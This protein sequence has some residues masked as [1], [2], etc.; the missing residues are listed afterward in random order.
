[1]ASM[2]QDEW[3]KRYLSSSYFSECFQLPASTAASTS[4]AS[5]HSSQLTP[6]IIHQHLRQLLPNNRIVLPPAATVQVGR[7]KGR[8]A[9]YKLAVYHGWIVLSHTVEFNSDVFWA[10][11]A[12]SRGET[13]MPERQWKHCERK[14]IAFT[15]WLLLDESR[16]ARC[17]T[18]LEQ[19]SLSWAAIQKLNYFDEQS[20]ENILSVAAISL[21]SG[22]GNRKRHTVTSKNVNSIVNSRP[23]SSPI[24][25]KNSTRAKNNHRRG[26]VEKNVEHSRLS[27]TSTELQRSE[28]VTETTHRNMHAGSSKSDL[29]LC[30]EKDVM[31][32]TDV[33]ED[34]HLIHAPIPDIRTQSPTTALMHD[35]NNPQQMTIILRT[36]IDDDVMTVTMDGRSAQSLQIGDVSSPA[37]DYGDERAGSDAMIYIPTLREF[38]HESL[39]LALASAESTALS[40]LS[41][42]VNIRKRRT[43]TVK[44]IKPILQSHKRAKSIQIS[45]L[46]ILPSHAVVSALASEI[47]SSRECNAGDE[48]VV[49]SEFDVSQYYSNF[50][51]DIAEQDNG[52]ETEHAE[53]PRHSNRSLLT[54]KDRVDPT[55]QSE[56]SFTSAISTSMDEGNSDARL[57][58][59]QP[60]ADGDERSD[61]QMDMNESEGRD[62]N[63]NGAE[64]ATR[65]HSL[66]MSAVDNTVGRF[67]HDYVLNSL[68][69]NPFEDHLSSE[70]AHHSR[71]HPQPVSPS[72][73]KATNT[74]SSTSNSPFT[75]NLLDDTSDSD[76]SRSPLSPF[77]TLHCDDPDN[78]EPF[79]R[80]VSGFLNESSVISSSTSKKTLNGLEAMEDV[81]RRWKQPYIPNNYLSQTND[82]TN[83][84]LFA[85]MMGVFMQQLQ[86]HFGIYATA[87]TSSH[88]DADI[89]R[90]DVIM[91]IFLTDCQQLISERLSAKSMTDDISAARVL[92]WR[93]G[94]STIMSTWSQ[95]K[96]EY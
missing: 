17:S 72:I 23:P 12:I 15:A 52:N 5:D 56:T 71:P 63:Y 53:L 57:R 37:T 10:L 70:Y 54:I 22:H 51:E 16:L 84:I 65:N 59:T 83:D 43:V 82:G 9:T 4:S 33:V 85:P 32:A 79:D 75:P 89:T 50:S 28:Q 7:L 92:K 60:R 27:G 68:G 66:T 41:T 18:L 14:C 38:D 29:I 46:Q 2:K 24:K 77:N 93:E 61:A 44:N 13:K 95:M 86:Q 34:D 76:N 19:L 64:E 8:Q 45:R 11:I 94:I 31:T 91:R 73:P 87:A 47:T 42:G 96:N 26:R 78:D 21:R 35:N 55:S 25:N 40:A 80:I 49:S 3:R 69:S 74:A 1:M 67:F 81:G 39:E 58:V 20:M 6:D 36:D 48:R 30:A 88:P 90:L 62:N